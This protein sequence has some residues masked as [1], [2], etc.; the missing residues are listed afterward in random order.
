[1]P[2]HKILLV[3]LV[4]IIVSYGC[5]VVVYKKK[6]YGAEQEYEL[7]QKAVSQAHREEKKRANDAVIF[8]K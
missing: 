4:L 1:M 7:Q 2:I 6:A 5:Y 8:P 3:A